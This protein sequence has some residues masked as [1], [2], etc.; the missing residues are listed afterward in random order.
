MEQR[1][2]KKK[3]FRFVP[4]RLDNAELQDFADLRIFLDFHAYPDGPIGGELLRL[5][6]AVVGEPLS[7]EAPASQSSR[8]KRPNRRRRRLPLPSGSTRRGRCSAL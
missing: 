5:L 4:V 7:E 1:T 8:M 6:H 2:T 3:G